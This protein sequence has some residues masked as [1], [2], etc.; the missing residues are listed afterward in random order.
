MPIVSSYDASLVGSVV[1]GYV[2]TAQPFGCI[3][4]FY[5]GVRALVPIA[6]LAEEYVPAAEVASRFHEGQVCSRVAVQPRLHLMT[7]AV[8]ACYP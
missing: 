8:D 7:V 1:H 4:G 2:R 3:V 6:Q 5:G